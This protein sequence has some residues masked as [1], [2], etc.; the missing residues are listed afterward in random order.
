MM[1][2]KFFDFFL[3][4]T[5]FNQYMMV[6]F[7]FLLLMTFLTCFLIIPITFFLVAAIF[8]INLTILNN[9]YFFMLYTT[10]LCEYSCTCTFSDTYVASVPLFKQFATGGNNYRS[11][12]FIKFYKIVD[13]KT[14]FFL[15]PC[16]YVS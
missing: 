7:L 13:C 8:L 2:L 1:V 4:F 3:C 12:F 9:Y 6:I 5:F 16:N 11:L 10:L 14:L 15:T